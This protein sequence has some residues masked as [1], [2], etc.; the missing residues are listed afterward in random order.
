[1]LRND[2][3]Y[4]KNNSIHL[5]KLKKHFKK[6]QYGLDYLFNEPATLNN[7]IT[8]F[9]DARKLFNKRRSN[10]L[11]KETNEIRNKLYKKEAIYNFLKEKVS[12]TNKQKIVLKNID[13]YLKK[14]NN[15]INIKIILHML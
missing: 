11:R 6:Y 12:L 2:E 15:D 1:M 3:R 9:K 4:L 13:K 10:F 5:K 7:G 14:L 8:V